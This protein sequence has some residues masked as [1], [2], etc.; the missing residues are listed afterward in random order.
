MNVH[1]RSIGRRNFIQGVAA[2][3]AALL[4]DRATFATT[5]VADAPVATTKAGRV[6]GYTDKGINVFKGIRYGADTTGRR[7]MP[8]LVPQP[9]SDIR[10]ALAYGPSA[11][12]QSRPNE[13]TSEDC[14]F[15]NVWTPGLRDGRKR[16]VMFY[17]HGGAY[18][19]GSGSSALYDGVRLCR[20]G[21]VVV[22]TVNHRLNAFGYLYLARFGG[23]E[24]AE[25][26]NAGQLDL[27]LALRWVKENIAEFGGDPDRVMVFGQSG[28][29]AKIATLMAMPSAEGLFHRAVTMSGQQVTASGALN[30]TL[31]TRTILEALKLTSERVGEIK[32]VPAERIVEVL[33]TRD[34]VL[35]F[36]GV[37]F[38]PVLDERTLRR[39][40]FYPDAPSQSARIPMI[41]GNTHDE[42]RAFLGGDASNFT[43]TWEQ[44]PEKLIPNM[45]VDIQPEIVIAEYRRLYPN[46]TPSDVFFAA[47]TAG[48]SWRGAVIEAEERAKSGSPSYVYQL[49]WATPRDGG[50]FGAPHASDIQLVFDNIDKPGA[51]A[52]G[53]TAQSMADQMSETYIAF[54]RTGNPNQKLIPRWTPYTLPRRETMIFDVPSRMENDPRG[55]ERRLFAKVP[56]I[57]PGT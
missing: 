3:G 30:A 10:D 25:S 11:P 18:S 27:V 1:Q 52:T 6:R 21:D 39:H 8:P 28:G 4:L 44:L 42:T 56:Y 40:P 16:T 45:R 26:G 9:W 48:R 23:P 14:L 35:P 33:G 15:L 13:R 32:S 22:V 12:Q 49:N 5:I 47:T 57:Q 2:G 53:P 46:Y 43:L 24:F 36:G 55:A 17:I 7:F 51:T 34:P 38:A 37:S 31:R 54:A 19:N 20:R 29:G 50:K 41:I